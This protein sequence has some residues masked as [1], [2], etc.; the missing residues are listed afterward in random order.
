[1]LDTVET[2]GLADE[3]GCNRVRTELERPR[4]QSMMVER[5]EDWLVIGA[6]C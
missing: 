2:M 3:E 6:A 4:E 5:A 1:M